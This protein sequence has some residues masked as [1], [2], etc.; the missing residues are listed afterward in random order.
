MTDFVMP[1]FLTVTHCVFLTRKLSRE[2]WL[3]SLTTDAIYSNLESTE[4]LY[5]YSV[6]GLRFADAAAFRPVVLLAVGGGSQ[7]LQL[8]GP[9]PAVDL[10]GKQ[11]GAAA[12]LEVTEAARSPDVLHLET[13]ELIISTI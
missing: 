3:L 1:C 8:S 13:K 5:T 7:F 6:V 10:V 2:C 12:A 4:L 11:V 9:E